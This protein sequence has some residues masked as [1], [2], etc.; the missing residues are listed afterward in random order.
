MPPVCFVSEKDMISLS[1][2]SPSYDSSQFLDCAN[3][4]AICDQKCKQTFPKDKK[5]LIACRI[6]AD[7][8]FSFSPD[9]FG[10]FPASAT[11]M[12]PTGPKQMLYVEED[13]LILTSNGFERCIG[14]LHRSEKEAE[15]LTIEVSNVTGEIL[16][17]LHISADHLVRLANG[18]LTFLPARLLEKSHQLKTRNSIVTVSSVGCSVMA[19]VYAPLVPSGTLFVNGIE[20]SC[21]APPSYFLMPDLAHNICHGALAPL[22]W[23]QHLKDTVE[24][25]SYDKECNGP[26]LTLRCEPFA[27]P[28]DGIHPYARFLMQCFLK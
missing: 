1:F 25:A 14:F 11:V 23:Y 20:C 17:A 9:E 12:T 2:D 10:C 8:K 15:Y 21:Y 4:Y 18:Q 19:G 24:S 22:R 27:L 26:L 3:D 13:D 5:S 16:P 7:K 6:A 28:V